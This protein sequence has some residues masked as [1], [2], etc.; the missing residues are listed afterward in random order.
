M[1][2]PKILT[3]M[4]IFYD[5]HGRVFVAGIHDQPEI[6]LYRRNWIPA[7]YTRE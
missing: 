4:T 3:G 1:N 6:F 7:K 2:S 5:R